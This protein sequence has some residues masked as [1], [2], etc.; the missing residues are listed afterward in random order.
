MQNEYVTDT[1]KKQMLNILLLSSI[2]IYMTFLYFLTALQHSHK[3]SAKKE[4]E[5]TSTNVLLGCFETFLREECNFT[6]YL[7]FNFMTLMFMWHCHVSPIHELGKTS[8]LFIPD[9]IPLP[10]FANVLK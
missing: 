8:S 10:G 3:K 1:S 2:I 6:S 4:K 9:A 7:D 5:K